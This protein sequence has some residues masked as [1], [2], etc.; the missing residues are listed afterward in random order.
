MQDTNSALG[1][2]QD[3]KSDLFAKDENRYLLS[4]NAKFDPLVQDAKIQGVSYLCTSCGE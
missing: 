2:T 1:L 4:Q 3:T